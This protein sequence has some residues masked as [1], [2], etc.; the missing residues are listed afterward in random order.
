MKV[1][2]N[3]GMMHVLVS[4]NQL[5]LLDLG[6]YQPCTNNYLVGTSPFY[7]IFDNLFGQPNSPLA[8]LSI[9]KK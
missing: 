7:Q 5:E 4:Q 8:R 3:L 2:Q 9:F 1:T 6:Q